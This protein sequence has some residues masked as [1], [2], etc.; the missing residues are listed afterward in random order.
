MDVRDAVEADAGRLASLTDTPRDV[1]QNL[2]HDRTV[3]VAEQDDELRGFVSYDAREGTVHVTQMDGDPATFQ[4][5]LEEPIRFA[6]ME[7][8]AVELLA[9][10]DEPELQDAAIAAGFDEIGS[11]PRFEGQP[12]TKLRMRE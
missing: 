12:T 5:L 6:R 11:G 8:M 3:R 1:M 7:G 9:P 4:R 2:I 10:A